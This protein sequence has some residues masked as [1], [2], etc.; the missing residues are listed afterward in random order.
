MLLRRV[1]KLENIVS[2]LKMVNCT[3]HAPLKEKLYELELLYDQY[4]VHTLCQALDVSR[5]TFYN[6]ILRNKRGNAWFEKRREEYC[7]LIRE[8]FDEYRQVLGAEKIRTILVQRGHQVSTE[9]V[10]RLMR[11]MGLSSIRTTAKQDY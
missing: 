8:V 1:T 3:V 9:Y 11:E 5:G 6:H 7:V 4:D 10:A 2:I